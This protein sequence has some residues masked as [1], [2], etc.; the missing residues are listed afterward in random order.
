MRRLDS[1]RCSSS[2]AYGLV[3]FA[4]GCGGGGSTP[5]AGLSDAA[6]GEEAGVAPPYCTSQSGVASVTDL[7]GI[8]VARM[9]GAE[10]VNSPIGAIHTEN[11]FFVLLNISQSGTELQL[12]GRY[13]DRT[14]INPQ[15]ALVP[16]I[17]PAAWAH[18]EK[19]VHRK[20]TFT[21][22]TDGVSTLA[23]SEYVELAGALPGPA[24]DPLPK[25]ASELSALQVIDEDG[26]GNPGITIVLNGQSISGSIYAVQEQITSVIAIPV[27]P[28]RVEGA[29]SFTSF[30]KILASNPTNI[31]S[32]YALSTTSS[33]PVVCDSTFAMVKI[34][35]APAIDGGTMDVGELDG[36]VAGDGAAL[37]GG[38]VGCEW[39]RAKEAV[40]FP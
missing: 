23:M 36:G 7:S 19:M 1:F 30:Q 18:T 11:V 25:N 12:D 29:L 13:C 27:A 2:L 35:D 6:G 4:L 34:A 39:V 33:D 26:D 9:V 17:V 32:L 10:I 22:G 16:V 38:V 40:L 15:N 21:A 31:A 37:D 28:N 24:T 8:W 20:G 14:E 3:A 5:D